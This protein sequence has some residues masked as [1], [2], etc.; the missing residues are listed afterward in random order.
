MRAEPFQGVI[1]VIDTDAYAGNFE[2]PMCAY[3]TGQVGDC[4]VGEEYAE[5]FKQCPEE[6]YEEAFEDLIVHVPDDHGC[7]RPVSIYATPGFW[8]DGM[9]NEWRDEDWGQPKTV[10]KYRKAVEQWLKDHPGEDH[11]DGPH[12]CP[13]YQ[14]VAIFFDKQPSP[15]LLL[16]MRKRAMAF[17]EVY[18]AHREWNYP[19][20]IL[21]FRLVKETVVVEVI[22]QFP[23]GV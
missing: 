5:M 3:L 15:E 6:A 23:A 10:E 22:E 20:N 7:C 18:A 17:P 9:G 11:F 1:F 2:R 19:F 16:L 8:N 14:S 21:G 13:S 4:G 12:R